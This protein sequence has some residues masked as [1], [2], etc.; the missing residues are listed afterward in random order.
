MLN[1]KVSSRTFKDSTDESN[2][3]NGKH[4]IVVED[5]SSN[6]LLIRSIDIEPVLQSKLNNN[7]LTLSDYY[8]QIRT[9]TMYSIERELG[10][11]ILFESYVDCLACCDVLER[12][13]NK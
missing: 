2:T 8:N 7:Q 5:T 4:Y 12:D 10:E 9:H 13:L 6:N 3:M 11:S 1:Y